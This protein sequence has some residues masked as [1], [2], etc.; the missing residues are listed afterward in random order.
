MQAMAGTQA[1]AMANAGVPQ[2]DIGDF[3]F[4][5]MMGGSRGGRRG[6]DTVA[7][8]VA[9]YHQR[10]HARR[11]AYTDKRDAKLKRH[12]DFIKTTVTR[13]ENK[14]KALRERLKNAGLTGG[15]LIP[16]VGAQEAQDIYEAASSGGHPAGMISLPPPGWTPQ[17]IGPP[18]PREKTGVFIKPETHEESALRR[19]RAISGRGASSPEIWGTYQRI[20]DTESGG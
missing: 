18:G 15:G 8:Q 14:Q 10:R 20:L 5:Q 3:G 11:K 16:L 4:D 1:Q 7:N 12:T 9:R 13:R 17:A 2:Q 6:K 19:A